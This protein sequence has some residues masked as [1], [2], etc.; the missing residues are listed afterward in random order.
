M[1]PD[2]VEANLTREIGTLRELLGDTRVRFR[3]RE[4]QS[5]S[6]QKLIDVDLEIRLALARP[7]SADL[8]L[9]VRRL[10]VC[11]RMLDPH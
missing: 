9:D 2:F 6:W 10:T 5:A 8:Q 4:T 3:H 7:L 1:P 11:L